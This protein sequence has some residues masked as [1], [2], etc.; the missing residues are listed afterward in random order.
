MSD[1]LLSW[2]KNVAKIEMGNHILADK[3]ACPQWM[4]SCQAPTS[5]EYMHF[6]KQD[7][8]GL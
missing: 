8:I 1:V 2:T 7:Q 6:N 5:D 4:F 3:P